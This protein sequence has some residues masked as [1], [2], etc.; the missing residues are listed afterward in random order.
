MLENSMKVLYNSVKSKL[1][2][3]N[4]NGEWKFKDSTD[5]MMQPRIILNG[6]SMFHRTHFK[7]SLDRHLDAETLT[8]RRLETVVE[9]FFKRNEGREFTMQMEEALEERGWKRKAFELTLD[10]SMSHPVIDSLFIVTKDKQSQ[11][12]QRFLRII[13]MDYLIKYIEFKSH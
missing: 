7:T 11:I 5:G 6:Q 9:A 10:A 13:L 1:F 4:K 3:K 2:S 12:K 8:E